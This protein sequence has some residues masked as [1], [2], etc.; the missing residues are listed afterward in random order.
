M[1]YNK[2]NQLIED[3]KFNCISFIVFDKTKEGEV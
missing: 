1:T 2:N 3:L